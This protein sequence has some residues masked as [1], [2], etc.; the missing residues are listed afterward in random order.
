M[1]KWSYLLVASLVSIAACKQKSGEEKKQ[2]VSI[3]SYINSQVADIDTSLYTIIKLDYVDSSHIDTTYVPREN[4]RALARD[5][6]ELPDIADKDN[7]KDYREETRFDEMLNRVAI[8]YVPEKPEKSLIQRQD[9]LI[10][11]DASGGK[12]R[13][14]IIDYLLNNRDSIVQKRM[15]WQVDR[16]FLVTTIKQKA[17]QPESISTTKVIW[18]EQEEQ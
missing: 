10:T 18:N 8:T 16:S 5:F 4:F 1:K 2:F 12:V 13:T 7:S 17:G 14:I 9:M 11:P 3:R 6:L 15:L